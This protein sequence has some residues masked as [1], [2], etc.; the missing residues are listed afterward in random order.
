MVAA[1]ARRAA[2]PVAGAHRAA[3]LRRAGAAPPPN[4][5]PKVDV[6][7]LKGDWKSEGLT[8]YRLSFPDQRYLATVD[9]DKLTITGGPGALPDGV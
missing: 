1:A 6:Q 4:L 2:V 8:D 5:I 9:G 7:D 3:A